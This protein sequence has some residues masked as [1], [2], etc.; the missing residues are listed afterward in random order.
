MSRV[1]VSYAGAD[2]FVQQQRTKGIDV[3][4]DGWTMVFWQSNPNGFYDKNGAFKGK[5]GVQARVD[6]DSAGEY[7][8][9]VRYLTARRRK[10]A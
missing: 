7:K 6:V 1:T 5:W 4:W 3:F 2:T 10:R 9:P 8:V